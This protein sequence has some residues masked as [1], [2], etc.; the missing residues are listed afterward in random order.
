MGE[1]AYTLSDGQKQKIAIARAIIMKPKILILDEAM[2]SMDSASEERIIRGI[3][4]LLPES[5]V[6]I[7]SHR[8]SSVMACDLAYYLKSPDKIV[9]GRPSRLLEEDP[10]FHELFAAQIIQPQ[11]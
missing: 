3:K 1:N 8:L 9:A 10:D 11:D 5:L 6:I 4:E 2:S 7:V